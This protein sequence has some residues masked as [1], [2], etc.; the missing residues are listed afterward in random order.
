MD[1][2]KIFDLNTTN[3]HSSVEE[4]IECTLKE[5]IALDV[6]D[7]H[8]IKFSVDKSVNQHAYDIEQAAGFIYLN[9]DSLIN[10]DLQTLREITRRIEELSDTILERIENE[11]D[12]K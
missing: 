10:D 6:A 9:Q 12:M 5:F 3:Q 4:P 11:K 8:G 7:F 1:R 2:M